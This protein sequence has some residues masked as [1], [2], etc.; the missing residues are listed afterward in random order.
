MQIV[1]T[2]VGYIKLDHLSQKM[3]Y[4]LCNKRLKYVKFLKQYIGVH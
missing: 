3:L 2:S 4:K 1:F